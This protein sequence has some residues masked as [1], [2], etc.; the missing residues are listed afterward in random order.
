[1]RFAQFAATDVNPVLVGQLRPA[2]IRRGGSAVVV[3][4]TLE[5]LTPHI[6]WGGRADATVLLER[7]QRQFDPHGILNPGRYVC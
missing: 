3:R 7:I 6:I 4:T 5:G 2:A 1:M